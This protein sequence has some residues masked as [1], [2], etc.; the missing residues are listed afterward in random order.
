MLEIVS[1]IVMIVL[2]RMKLGA[3]W[4]SDIFHTKPYRPSQMNQVFHGAIDF[5]RVPKDK[6]R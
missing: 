2:L 4:I 6:K 5:A 1:L 3:G